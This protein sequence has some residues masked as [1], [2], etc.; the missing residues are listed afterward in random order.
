M[1]S[2]YLKNHVGAI[3]AKGIA[4]TVVAQPSNPQ[5]YLALY[6]LHHLQETERRL[7]VNALKRKAGEMHKEW[8]V[9]RAGREKAAAET[10]QRGMARFQARIRAKKAAEV[11]LSEL[12]QEAEE[13]AEE[14]LDQEEEAKDTTAEADTEVNENN[15]DGNDNNGDSAK[16]KLE[17]LE[18]QLSETRREF[19]L[20]QRFILSLQ[21]SNLGQLKLELA[22][23]ADRVAIAQG[24]IHGQYDR[25][26]AQE[27]ELVEVASN[28]MTPQPQ[29]SAAATEL[30]IRLGEHRDHRFIS[31]PFLQFCALRCICY[32]LLDS[33]PKA[34]DS[35]TK[36]AALVKPTV[37]IKQL[38]AFNPV[39]TY[40][41][42]IPLKLEK[43]I[44]N[45]AGGSG[46]D[47]D[48]DAG[49]GAGEEEEEESVPISQ[50]KT[51]QV[52]RAQRVL[53][54]CLSDAEYVCEVDAEDYFTEDLVAMAEEEAEEAEES[55]DE[56]AGGA[57]KE[58]ADAAN[59]EPAYNIVAEIAASKESIE[60]AKEVR[61]VVQK[62]L[63]QRGGTLLWGLLRFLSAAV[64]YRLA[65]DAVARQRQELGLPM[66]ESEELAEDEEEDPLN[67]EVLVDS[68]S[69]EVDLEA[70]QSL[71]ERIGC[72]VAESLA[73]V[74]EARDTRRREELE[75]KAAHLRKQMDDEDEE[76]A[77]GEDEEAPS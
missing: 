64:A 46:G 23:A 54:V 19:F 40:D 20:S 38:R 39:A 59:A 76:G 60:H 74:W 47:D 52:R 63:K 15:D 13:E 21:K 26:A 53:R 45:A 66:K 22:D 42:A 62:Q 11:E 17:E 27:A 10:I 3:L 49:A 57:K 14:L 32:L 7:D 28:P 29:L 36:V 6:L 16:E 70:V 35:A 55:E 4:E 71:Q 31:I 5:E 8:T 51:R 30:A 73:K 37:L 56:E 65:R 2:A 33:T 69:G 18:E 43:F 34:T 12:Y 72:D 48:D 58:G 25:S 50:P 41:R 77:G 75:L 61:E 24:F 9:Q 1:D 68:E 44:P 67:D